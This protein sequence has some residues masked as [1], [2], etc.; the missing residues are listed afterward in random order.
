MR[1]S[2]PYCGERDA[3]EFSYLGDAKLERPD[4]HSPDALD[5]FVSY[6]YLRENPAGEH[7]ELW[8]HGAGCQVWLTVTRNT[9][10]HEISSVEPVAA[11]N[12]RSAE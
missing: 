6:V 3:R 2:C 10:T 7:R 11:S 4:P 1:I 9:R 5:R 12:P 8:Y